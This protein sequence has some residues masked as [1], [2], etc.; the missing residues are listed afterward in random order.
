MLFGFTWTFQR[1]ICK[2]GSEYNL[3]LLHWDCTKL[4]LW[5]LD[6]L[7]NGNHKHSRILSTRTI[8]KQRS[9]CLLLGKGNKFSHWKCNQMTTKFQR[10]EA[11]F[12][13]LVSLFNPYKTTNCPLIFLKNRLYLHI[14]FE[15]E[16]ATIIIPSRLFCWKLPLCLPSSIFYRLKSKLLSQQK[17]KMMLE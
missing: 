3:P 5:T 4:Y 2:S 17:M 6:G 15:V 1:P 11:P 8:Q 10:N 12:L 14:K 7:S 9:N 13:F 16:T